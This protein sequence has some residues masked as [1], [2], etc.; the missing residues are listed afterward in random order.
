MQAGQH[1]ECIHSSSVVDD[2]DKRLAIFDVL[3]SSIE[4]WMTTRESC[5]H[6]RYT[7]VQGPVRTYGLRGPTWPQLW[8]AHVW[9]HRFAMTV[10]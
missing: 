10:K 1:K 3:A 9:S 8:H 5:M 4:L 7:Y 6:M 2:S